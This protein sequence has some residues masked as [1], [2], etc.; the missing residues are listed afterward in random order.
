MNEPQVEQNGSKWE[1][2]VL[3]LLEGYEYRE[4]SMENNR[5][6]VLNSAVEGMRIMLAELETQ[7]ENS[8]GIWAEAKVRAQVN[9]E[10]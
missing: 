7:M 5:A 10:I 3:R 6:L 2:R 9:L 4:V 8:G 1:R